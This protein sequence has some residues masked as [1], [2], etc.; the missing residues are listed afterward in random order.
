MAPRRAPARPPEASFDQMD[1]T[2]LRAFAQES[3]RLI[4]AAAATKANEVSTAIA[5]DPEK[6]RS[7]KLLA[8]LAAHLLL[9][10][11]DEEA[12]A[13]TNGGSRRVEKFLEGA[14][15]LCTVS[16]DAVLAS[17]PGRHGL[18]DLA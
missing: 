12:G 14:E 7:S 15:L 4:A 10:S 6:M 11:F 5:R 18:T 17:S 16:L 2:E 3:A 9:V 1:I 13:D 8:S